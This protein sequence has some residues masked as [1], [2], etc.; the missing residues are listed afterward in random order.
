LDV[1]TT[2]VIVCVCH[3]KLKGYTYLLT[4]HG[5]KRLGGE[6]TKGPN[7]HKS[8][9]C[10]VR[11]VGA[12]CRFVGTDDVRSGA[13]LWRSPDTT[14]VILTPWIPPFTAPRLFTVH[15]RT[16]HLYL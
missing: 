9:W 7:V 3:A 6:L 2:Y 1:L 4:Y 16:A 12:R 13:I 14:L 11:T 8:Y 5:T 10:D 15:V